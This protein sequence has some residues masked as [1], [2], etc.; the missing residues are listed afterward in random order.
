MAPG[1]PTSGCSSRTARSTTCC[2]PARR[3]AGDDERQP[4]R[5]ADRFEDDEALE[6]LAGIADLFLAARPPDRHPQRRL[7]AARH[8]A[9]PLVMRR[10][11]GMVPSA[12]AAGAAAP[13]AGL[14]RELKNTFCLAAR[15]PR[16]GRRTTSAISRT[17][18]RSRSYREAIEHIERSSRSRP[19]SSRTTS[20]PTTARPRYAL[21]REG[22]ERVAV[23]HHHAHL[24]AC[25]AEHGETGPAVGAIFDGT[26]LGNDG[27]MWGGEILVGDLRGFERAGHLGRSACPAATA[28]SG[29]RGGWR[30][31]GCAGGGDDERPL[32]GVDA[33]SV[34]R[35]GR[36]GASGPRAPARRPAACS[37]PSPRSAASAPR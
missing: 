12:R 10:S 20:T 11:R 25:L 5:R 28:P 37:T 33:A 4:V 19:R 13:P 18:R 26:G 2:S 6:R 7:G 15:R 17:P 31:R 32:A 30:A 8:G 16:L 9:R 3:A 14:R 24:A 35:G 22:V 1:S 23:Q 21:A 36:A 27:T 34:A 29:S